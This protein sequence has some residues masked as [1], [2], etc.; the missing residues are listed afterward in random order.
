M[1]NSPCFETSNLVFSCP[2]TN[3]DPTRYQDLTSGHYGVKCWICS[4]DNSAFENG[5]L[6]DVDLRTG[7]ILVDLKFGPNMLGNTLDEGPLDGYAIFMTDLAGERIS[8]NPVGSVPKQYGSALARDGCCEAAA[9]SARVTV[10]LPDGHEQVRFE[11]VPVLTGLGP[12]AVGRISVP[13]GDASPFNQ[14]VTP[15]ASHKVACWMTLVIVL[16]RKSV[17]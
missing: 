17:V 15:S 1:L 11:V 9:Y 2:G 8:N 3:H 7:Y 10:R 4:F 6:V 16:D 13:V 12:L 5:Q 14:I